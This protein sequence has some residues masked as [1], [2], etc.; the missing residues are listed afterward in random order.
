MFSLLFNPS[1]RCSSSHRPQYCIGQLVDNILIWLISIY[2]FQSGQPANHSCTCWW[3]PY[4]GFP[5]YLKG[6]ENII[7]SWYFPNFFSSLVY[8]SSLAPG[9]LLIALK[10][11]VL[12]LPYWLSDRVFCESATFEASLKI[13]TTKRRRRFKEWDL[14]GAKRGLSNLLIYWL[15]D[16]EDQDLPN[17]LLFMKSTHNGESGSFKLGKLHFWFDFHVEI[18]IWHQQLHWSFLGNSLFERDIK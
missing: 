18:E 16:L 10:V 15:W 11:A 8:W 3:T 9:F 6:Y 7:I 14:N 5:I 4:Y 13:N 2:Q 12:G 1:S 17:Y